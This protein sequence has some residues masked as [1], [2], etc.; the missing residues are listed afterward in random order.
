MCRRLLQDKENGSVPKSETAINTAQPSELPP[1]PIDQD[2]AVARADG[3]QR[4]EQQIA[5]ILQRIDQL[6]SAVQVTSSDEAARQLD[7]GDA[8]TITHQGPSTE[9]IIESLASELDADMQKWKKA[10]AG[11]KRNTMVS[12]PPDNTMTTGLPDLTPRLAHGTAEASQI[13]VMPAASDLAASQKTSPQTWTGAVSCRQRAS[14]IGTAG[15]VLASAANTARF[16]SCYNRAPLYR[17][18]KCHQGTYA[19]S[20]TKRPCDWKD[21]IPSNYRA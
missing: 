8:D 10:E 17:L 2:T 6:P 12:V 9:S 3:L 16:S 7:E 13:M 15:S 11:K 20:A 1:K 5:T 18:R 14:T 19:T 4:I 21:L